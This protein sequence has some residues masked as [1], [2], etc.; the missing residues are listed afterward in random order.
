M[1][2]IIIGRREQGKT[3]LAK[4]MAH[5]RTPRLTVD[6]RALWPKLPR[7]ADDDRP[8]FYTYVN[9]DYILEDLRDGDDVLIVPDDLEDSIPALAGPAREFISDNDSRQLTITFDE[10]KLYEKELRSYWSWIMR[11]S[12]RE[13]TTIILT[14][15]RPAD[16]PTDIRALADMWCIFRTTQQHDLDAI[17]ERCGPEVVALV[18]VLKPFEFV[19]WNDAKAEMQH[20]KNP[21]AWFTPAP[22]PLVGDP[23]KSRRL[24]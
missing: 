4:Y 15:H 8:G 19:S 12:P 17:E 1:I 16:I 7:E 6:P 21:A 13:R 20:H 9:P 2:V 23:I 5:A 10:A 24:F 18:Q 11:C 3:T 14:A 22:V